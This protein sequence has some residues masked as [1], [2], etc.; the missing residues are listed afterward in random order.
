M[1]HHHIRLL[2][3]HNH[4]QHH[5]LHDIL[6]PNNALFLPNKLFITSFHGF[7]VLEEQHCIVREFLYTIHQSSELATPVDRKEAVGNCQERDNL[8]SSTGGAGT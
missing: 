6:R 7:H 2:P 3:N 4:L 5:T 1:Y 8:H